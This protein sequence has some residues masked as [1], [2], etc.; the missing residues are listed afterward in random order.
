MK[1]LPIKISQAKWSK[2]LKNFKIKFN[3]FI[4]QLIQFAKVSVK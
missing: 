3:T 4:E 2:P 1:V